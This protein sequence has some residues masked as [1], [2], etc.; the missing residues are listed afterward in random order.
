M[1]WISDF[2]HGWRALVRT[3]AFLVTSVATLALA[4]GAVVGMFSVVN[5]VLLRPLPFPAPDRL[6]VVAG[7]A[8][9][10]DLP[11]RFGLGQE[12]Y[13][14]YKERSQLLEGIFLF[15]GGTSTLR[16]EDRVERI[17]MA[18]PTN[19]I[20]AT[21]GVRPQVGRLPVPDD[22]DRVVLISDRLWSTWFGR[23]PAVVGKTYFVSGEMRQ[24]IG[25][26][27][28][29]FSFPSEDT[30]LWVAGEVRPAEISP[31]QLGAPVVVRMKPGVTRE[32]L[33]AELTRLSKEL[34]AR[35]G[36]SP[37]YKRI[38]EQHSAVVDPVLDRMSVQRR[39][40]RSGCCWAG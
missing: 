14:H 3:P 4:I 16:T 28:P 35:F 21:L 34:P 20:Y 9:G 19:D 26:M 36:G 31:G 23:D 30:L 39:A 27:P 15:S 25:V 5:T 38:I 10:S 32:Q 8:P 29:A 6:V 40:P 33:A 12:F 11:E 2:R 18:F 37:A 22:G 24:V 7:T 17:P 13:L 1:Q